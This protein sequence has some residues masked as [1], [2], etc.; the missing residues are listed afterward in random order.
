[1]PTYSIEAHGD[2][3][4]LYNVQAE[5]EEEAIAKWERGDA[6]EPYLA[7]MMGMAI[8]RIECDEA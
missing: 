2:V 6:G 8:Y 4:E 1:M 3:R 7:E 5:S